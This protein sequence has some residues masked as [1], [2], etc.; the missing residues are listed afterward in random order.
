MEASHK[1][2]SMTAVVA[3]ILLYWTFDEPLASPFLLVPTNP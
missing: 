2:R 1:E 3:R